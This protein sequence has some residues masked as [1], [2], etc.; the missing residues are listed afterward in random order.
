MCMHLPRREQEKFLQKIMSTPQKNRGNT[1]KTFLL[2][3]IDQGWAPS[4]IWQLA[5]CVL[6]Y[7]A[8]RLSLSNRPVWDGL[9]VP[10]KSWSQS[11]NILQAIFINV[12][13]VK[14]SPMAKSLFRGWRNR[15]TLVGGAA[16]SPHAYMEGKNLQ[17]LQS[18][19]V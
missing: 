19:V 12:L 15:L 10:R 13:L 18:T 9:R 1:N 11:T 2:S 16:K 6:G 14:A 3:V 17:L 4:Y 5:G 7:L 8:I